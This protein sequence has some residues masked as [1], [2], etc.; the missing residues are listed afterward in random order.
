LLR[1]FGDNLWKGLGYGLF[2]NGGAAAAAIFT[3][4][5]YV[6]YFVLMGFPVAQYIWIVPIIRRMRNRGQYQSAR[7]VL[8]ASAVTV[9]LYGAA[10]VYFRNVLYRPA[11]AA[12]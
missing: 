12:P 11:R 4:M 10:W 9:I 8:I 3:F 5:L 6:G 2:I 7:G 1:G